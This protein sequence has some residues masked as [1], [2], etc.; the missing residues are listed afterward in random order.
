MKLSDIAELKV[1]MI[2]VWECKSQFS[3]SVNVKKIIELR[4]CAEQKK[5]KEL[6]IKGKSEEIIKRFLN[7]LL[8]EEKCFNKL[9]NERT[10][11]TNVILK[12]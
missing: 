12:L 6:K 9:R 5:S 7:D 3:C 10:N 2:Y 4:E 1:W 8:I 11:V